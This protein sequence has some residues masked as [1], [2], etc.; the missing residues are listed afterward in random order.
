[1]QA[2]EIDEIQKIL[3]A[4]ILKETPIWA[5]VLFFGAVLSA[6]LSTASGTLL[7]P[8]S[9]LTEN[10]LQPFTKHFTDQKLIWLLRAVL[11]CVG[12]VSTLISVSSNQTMYEMVEAGYLGRK[13]GKG[14][15]EYT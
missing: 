14:F 10:V 7:A 9:L 3:P 8:A 11:I 12:I 1:M 13:T 2:I 6:I 15:F 4:L 5:Q